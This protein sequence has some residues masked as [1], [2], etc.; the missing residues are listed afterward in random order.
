MVHRK[1]SEVGTLVREKA[2]G[3]PDNA[4]RAW[5]KVNVVAADVRSRAEAW[6]EDRRARHRQPVDAESMTKEEL[7]DLARKADVSGR[8][9][10]TKAQLAAA[11]RKLR[12]S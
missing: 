5:G 8:S 4:S 1:V 12:R 10:M 6:N 3:L 7:M 11:L 2:R 9:S